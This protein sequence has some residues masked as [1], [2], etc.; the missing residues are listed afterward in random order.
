MTQKGE[1]VREYL[2]RTSAVL[3]EL[4]ADSITALVGAIWDLWEADRTLYICG[5]GGSASTAS[6]MACDLRKQTRV[7]GR[8]PLR[9]ISI[10]DNV[11]ILTAWANDAGLNSIFAEQVRSLGRPGDAL[12]CLSCSGIS[13]NILAAID[14]AR[15]K[16]MN[17]LALGGFNGGPMRDHADVYV[18]VPSADYG[19]VESA[20]LVL[21]H[22]VTATLQNLAVASRVPLGVIDP[23]KP[24]VILDRDGVI[25]QNLPG[26]V[27]SWDEFS[28]IPGALEGLVNLTEHG[29]RVV[30]LTNQANIGR[31]L[32]PPAQL[33]EIHRRML[34][35]VVR[36]GAAIEAIYVCPHAPDEG[37]GCRK[38]A[39]GLLRRAAD[40]LEFPLEEAYL[41]G[42]HRTDIEAAR[43]A[44]T[45]AVLVLSGRG[46]QLG[47][48]DAPTPDFIANDLRAAA[49]L[50]TDRHN[51]VFRALEIAAH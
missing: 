10:T 44:G 24:V 34:E 12:L 7:P 46:S 4:D 15:E 16:D 13:A 27:G 6:H 14:A 38:P 40:E 43:A 3:A 28:F 36:A 48:D 21:D 49:Q 25:N 32:M 22:C 47:V 11:A 5:N 18:H 51:G 20:H 41:I 29:H 39:P 42:D 9:A 19:V 33:H 1:G 50:V 23:T 31:G 17:V 8:T 37:C 26:S 35:E 30:V 45:R 2:E